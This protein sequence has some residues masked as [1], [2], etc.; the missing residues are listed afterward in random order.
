[1]PF[2]T[3]FKTSSQTTP[4]KR[5]H[6][7]SY[8]IGWVATLSCEVEAARLML[9]EE[10]EVQSF[11]RDPNSY[12]LG[13]AGSHN[14]AIV[15][16]I[17]GRNGMESAATITAHMVRSFPNIRLCVLVGIGGGAP[18]APDASN[19]WNDIRL[20][21]VVV[22]CT[23]DNRGTVSALS[24][25]TSLLISN[26]GASFSTISV[27]P[28]SIGHRDSSFHTSEL[29]APSTPAAEEECKSILTT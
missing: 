17:K 29:Y 25:C 22:S 7:T 1:M 8:T 15:F 12:I 24:S 16:P 10:H 2:A 13:R 6:H 5:F 27:H 9:D 18:Q 21:D 19:P 20:G 28:L 11:P 14:V 3:L 4:G 23:D 26:Q